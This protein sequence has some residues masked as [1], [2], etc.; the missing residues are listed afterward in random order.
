M[1]GRRLID[2]VPPRGLLSPYARPV[3]W[4]LGNEMPEMS[5]RQPAGGTVLRRVRDPA[6]PDVL[7]LRDSSLG[8]G[9]VLPCLRSSCSRRSGDSRRGLLIATPRG[10]SPKR[11]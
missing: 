4:R 10:T 3:Y 1:P 9:Q 2:A 8:G 5:A 7:E 6:G 11:S